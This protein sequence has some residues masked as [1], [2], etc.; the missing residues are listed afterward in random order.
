MAWI[1]QWKRKLEKQLK[2][3]PESVQL[4][5]RALVL[6]I[7]LVG[8]IRG[9]WKNYSKLSKTKHHC[10]LKS[11]R[12]T[13]VVCWEVVDSQIEIVEVYYVGTHEKAPY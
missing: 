4:S 11:G 6:E 7:E 12:P 3:L 2:E 10:H 5:F 13:Y 8:P 1:V 9:N